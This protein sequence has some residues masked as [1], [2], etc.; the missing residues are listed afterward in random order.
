MSTT[1]CRLQGVEKAFGDNAV[2]K[3]LNLDLPAGLVTVLMG[4]NG[5]GKSTLVKIL[6]GVHRLDAGT[7][8]LA[9][10]PFSP[11]SPAEAIRAGVVTVH[12]SI[13]DGV[14]PDLDVASNLLIDRLAE[15]GYGFFIKRRKLYS[16]AEA[17][18]ARMG[19]SL[20]VRQPVRELGV[21]DRQLIAIARAMAHDPRL[22]ILDEPTSSLSAAE[23]E[24]LFGIIEGFKARGVAILYISHRMS[25]IRR[26]ADRIVSM[27]DGE[28][29]G[30]FESG[31]LDYEGAVNAMLGH[32]MSDVDIVIPEPGAPVLEIADM[33]LRAGAR[34]F[35]MTLRRNE[36][37]A[38]TGLLGSGKSVL[39]QALFGLKPA[40]AGTLRL[41]G[42]AY[43]PKTAKQAIA[44]GVFMSSK[45]RASNAVVPDF[46]LARNM[47]LPFLD[48]YSNLSFV[49][50]H[51]ERA[52]AAEMIDAL[53]IVCRGGGDDIRTLSGGNQQKVML[54]RWLS[55]HCRL[56]LLDEPF[57]GVD[58]RARRDI[59]RKIRETAKD[60]A[61]LVFVSELDEALEIA[62]RI[63][64]LNEHAIAGEFVNRDVDLNALLTAV[65][66]TVSNSGASAPQAA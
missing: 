52:T 29:S 8:T 65:T 66:G 41:E 59:G 25:D 13:N 3:R 62:D 43:A 46:N 14:I 61:T 4:A 33:Q 7:V 54:A 39:A 58:I 45:D 28:I 21:A 49:R 27:R 35:S 18:A 32:R 6:S 15:P 5:A 9:D 34:P 48:R 20:N 64:V 44:A 56:L 55:Q 22:L 2:L 11:S 53:T 60:R 36:V 38:V 31:N 42:R 37:I 47:T 1:L 26:I 12:Q 51:E 10:R 16:D 63:V 23:A 50:Q 57:Q 40:P 19:L 17:I 30:T 24:R